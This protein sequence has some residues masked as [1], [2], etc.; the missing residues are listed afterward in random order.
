MT[1]NM[2]RSKGITKPGEQGSAFCAKPMGSELIVGKCTN[3]LTF[4]DEN[5]CRNSRIGPERSC[6]VAS[7]RIV[8]K[9]QE[10][11]SGGDGSAW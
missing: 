5:L 10:L 8:A 11:S 6:G 9:S 7:I 4:Q 2:Q 1:R 3:A